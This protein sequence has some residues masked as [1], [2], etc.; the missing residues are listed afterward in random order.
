MVL[1]IFFFFIQRIVIGRHQELDDIVSDLLLTVQNI[2]DIS[3]ST[4]K[5]STTCRKQL[6]TSD[7]TL[8]RDNGVNS[9][10]P[11]C[12]DTVNRS[13]SRIS[14]KSCISSHRPSQSRDRCVIDCNCSTTATLTPTPSESEG[15]TSR[16]RQHSAIT[17]TSIH[18]YTSTH[19]RYYSNLELLRQQQR[20]RELIMALQNQ[21]YGCSPSQQSRSVAE[22]NHGS[23]STLCDSAINFESEENIPYHAREDSRPFTYG[24]PAGVQLSP[25]S[26]SPNMHR[27]PAGLSSPSLVRKVYGGQNDQNVSP[28]HKSPSAWNEFEEMLLRRREKIMNEKYSIGDGASSDVVRNEAIG[29]KKWNTNNTS[30]YHFNEPLKRSNTMDGTFGSGISDDE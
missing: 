12:I 21:S 27:K 10:N 11:Y 24:N 2:P 14:D 26:N 5:Q 4:S 18:T 13:A 29:A 30:G 8:K 9:A 25:I 23:V 15:G 3:R 6:F 7:T 28:R 1:I 19:D 16:L 20:E 22:D 17:P